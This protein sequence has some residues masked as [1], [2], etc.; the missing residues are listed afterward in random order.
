MF[1][2]ITIYFGRIIANY[3]GATVRWTYGTI[4]ITIFKK[5]KYTYSEYVNGPND[6][7]DSFDEVGHQFNNKIVGII[8]IALIA[9]MIISMT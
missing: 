4:W 2:L 6:S 9:G 7:T 3:I 5:P 1:E 8:T